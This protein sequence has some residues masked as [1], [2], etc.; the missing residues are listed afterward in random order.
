MSSS[1]LIPDDI[2]FMIKEFLFSRKFEAIALIKKHASLP[3]ALSLHNFKGLDNNINY[4]MRSESWVF[5]VLHM[6]Q[7][8]KTIRDTEAYMLD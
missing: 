2:W 4:L 8:E 5:R 7:V 3:Y 6:R 1:V